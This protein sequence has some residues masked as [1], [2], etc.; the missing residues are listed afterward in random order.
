MKACVFEGKKTI[1]YYEDWPDPVPGPNQVLI[2]VHYCAI[3]GSDV[4]N[5]KH[6][7]YQ[8]PL[9]M[10]H[11]ASGEIVAVGEGVKDFKIGDRVV[12]INVDL[13]TNKGEGIGIFMDGAFAELCAVYQ[14]DVFT[15]PESI[16]MIDAVLI[17]SF[18]NA[19]RGIN[20]SRI[21]AGER[22]MIIGGGSIGL[23]FL[24]MLLVEKR[25]EYVIVVEP[26]EFLRSRALE[27]GASESFKP[28][29][30]K[31]KRFFKKNGAPTFVF[32]CAGNEKSIMMGIQ[33]IEK[34]GTILLEGFSKGN[35]SI[36]M[37]LLNNR[38]VGIKGSLGHNRGDV[39]DAIRFF[40]TG[41]VNPDHFITDM[42]SLPELDDHFKK[43]MEPGKRRFIKT[44]VDFTK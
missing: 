28:N 11:E 16:A 25:P 42:I 22:I 32:D 6:V 34:G 12:P 15:V 44:V 1:S 8:V 10:G 37:F 35:I 3:C 18:A 4:S 26:H 2:K 30:T 43:Y 19:V 27:I 33:L 17:E 13:D 24:A 14:K 23:S 20:L 5:Y 38:E 41:N 31:I 40:T 29:Y 21:A 39:L 9:I 36:P 7:I